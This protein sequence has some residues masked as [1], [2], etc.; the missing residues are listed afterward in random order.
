V[1]DIAVK[2][3][4]LTFKKSL[5]RPQDLAYQTYKA[6]KKRELLRYSVEELKSM[7]RQQQQQP[8]PV[9]ETGGVLTRELLS[10]LNSPQ[11]SPMVK[12][13]TILG[14]AS[15]SGV[16]DGSAL[17][18]Q[19]LEVL[20]ETLFVKTFPLYEAIRKTPAN[21]LTHAYDV[22]TTPDPNM[23]A[24]SNTVSTLISELSAV[25]FSASTYVRKTANVS[26]L[27]IGRGV[28]FLEL[29]AVR[30]GGMA[31]DP[32]KMEL[33]GGVTKIAYDA[34]TLICQGNGS[35]SSGTASNEGGTYLNSPTSYD[36]LRLVLGSVTGS[37]YA[38]NAAIQLEQGSLNMTQTLRQA[39]GKA[40]MQG[41]IPDWIVMT[42]N[43]KT[44]L[45]EENEQNK[46]YND[47]VEVVPGVQVNQFAWANGIAKV[48]AVPGF[49]FGSY[50][51]PLSGAPVE[52]VYF[53]QSDEI[54][55][56]WL[57]NEGITVLELPAALDYTLS[58]RY[59]I[60]Q[61]LSLAVKAPLWM[62]KVR[63]LVS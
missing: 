23:S 28:S 13:S 22:M 32:T 44:Q 45:D 25:T 9:D 1:P 37:S 30:G 41:G 31:W 63:R 62:G 8:A 38:S 17:I 40:A 5:E 10:G 60:F 47:T 4:P 11:V 24:T 19:D 59:V 21:G 15:G 20:V 39:L 55:I 35:Y 57:Y 46:R 34:Q 2:D 29:A 43:A 56:P 58:Q 53:L 7:L 26:L 6:A 16:A 48:L 50:T 36:G 18:R 42:I 49:S 54:E 61:M 3:G 14:T 52:D 27:G 51:S 33:A 12:T